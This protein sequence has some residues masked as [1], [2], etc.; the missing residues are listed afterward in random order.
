MGFYIK[1]PKFIKKWKESKKIR[2]KYRKKNNNNNLVHQDR[3]ALS[4]K[5][6]FSLK[7]QLWKEAPTIKHMDPASFRLDIFGSVICFEINKKISQT[8]ILRAEIDHIKP[9][10]KGG[11]L[12]LQNICLL[13]QLANKKKSNTYIDNFSEQKWNSIRGRT[14]D[15]NI[16]YKLCFWKKDHSYYANTEKAIVSAREFYKDIKTLNNTDFYKKYNIELI[17]KPKNISSPY[18]VFFYKNKIA[19]NF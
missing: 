2:S 3:P 13:N 9:H 12:D 5:E 7:L 6:Y 10:S 18:K 8:S 14:F 17:E 19:K 4:A 11:T 15:K 16:W 1:N